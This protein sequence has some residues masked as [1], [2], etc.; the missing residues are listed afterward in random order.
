[1]GQNRYGPILQSL[2]SKE[3]TQS[4]SWKLKLG[5]GIEKP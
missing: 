1:M 5:C 2:K 3:K 4:Q